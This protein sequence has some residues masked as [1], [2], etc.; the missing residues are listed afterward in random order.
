M[1]SQIYIDMLHIILEL[2][3]SIWFFSL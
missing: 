2:L 3:G 1:I